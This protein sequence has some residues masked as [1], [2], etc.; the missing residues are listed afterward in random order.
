MFAREDMKN[1]VEINTE[2]LMQQI[3]QTLD[4]TE[5]HKVG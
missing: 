5:W 3:S 2:F 4:S 1:E